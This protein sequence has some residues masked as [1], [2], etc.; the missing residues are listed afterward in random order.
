MNDEDDWT[1]PAGS[2]AQPH[3]IQP[4]DLNLEDEDCYSPL[5]DLIDEKWVGKLYPKASELV[6]CCPGCFVTVCRRVS[7]SQD[8]QYISESVINCKFGDALDTKSAIKLV[9]EC[10]ACDAELGVFEV[11]EGLFYLI[12]VLPGR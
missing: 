1:P 8:H 12:N 5:A 2:L 7:E 3:I 11:E 4:V 10:D 9:L 6:L